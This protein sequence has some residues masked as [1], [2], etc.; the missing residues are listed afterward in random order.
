MIKSVR[1]GEFFDLVFVDWSPITVW[2]GGWSLLLG[3]LNM[4]SFGSASRWEV[5]FQ[6]EW[7]SFGGDVDVRW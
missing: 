6:G 4:N 7:V 3:V 1:F 5:K 2:L